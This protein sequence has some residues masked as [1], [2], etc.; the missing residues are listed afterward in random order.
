[1]STPTILVR[2]SILSWLHLLRILKS[3]SVICALA[4]KRLSL[5]MKALIYSNKQVN[6]CCVAAT[7]TEHGSA[8]LMPTSVENIRLCKLSRG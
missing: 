1:M 3:S 7:D 6:N 5:K 2:A 4:L 8:D